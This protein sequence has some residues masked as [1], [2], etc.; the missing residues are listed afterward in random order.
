[1]RA[2]ND[3]HAMMFDVSEDI[4]VLQITLPEGH[5]DENTTVS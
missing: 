1:M 5:V 3:D 4:D 2:L